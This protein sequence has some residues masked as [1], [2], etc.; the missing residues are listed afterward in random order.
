MKTEKEWFEEA[1]RLAH[2]NDAYLRNIDYH[3]DKLEYVVAANR[4]YEQ[5]AISTDMA[6]LILDALE[7]Y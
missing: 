7:K 2:L 6:K 4:G 3:R 5:I 1:H